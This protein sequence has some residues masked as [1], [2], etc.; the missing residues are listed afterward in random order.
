MSVERDSKERDRMERKWNLDGRDVG[1]L[2]HRSLLFS[3]GVLHEFV[4]LRWCS[5]IP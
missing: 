3:C 5:T 1:D 2:Y 4:E